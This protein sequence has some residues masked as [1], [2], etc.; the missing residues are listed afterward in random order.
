MCKYEKK[1]TWPR[2]KQTEYRFVNTSRPIKWHFSLFSREIGKTLTSSY[3][4]MPQFKKF[5]FH[6]TSRSKCK[7]HNSAITWMPILEILQT[8][9]QPRD[10]RAVIAISIDACQVVRR[11]RSSS[12]E[13]I[14]TEKQ[15]G[16]RKTEQNEEAGS[17]RRCYAKPETRD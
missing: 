2:Y 10:F 17:R 3:N 1:K 16:E 15:R 14:H 6:Y 9:T 11:T 12:A 7:N 4:D 5:Q 8:H 13:T